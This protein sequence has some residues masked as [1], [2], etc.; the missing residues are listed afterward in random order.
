ML[1]NKLNHSGE[2]RGNGYGDNGFLIGRVYKQVVIG[3]RQS[4]KKEMQMKLNKKH[5]P[6]KKLDEI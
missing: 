6:P 5:R 1:I 2:S 3:K 4:N